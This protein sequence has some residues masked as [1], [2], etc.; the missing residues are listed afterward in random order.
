VLY[1]HR[2]SIAPWR[3]D[4][5]LKKDYI[6]QGPARLVG[7]GRSEADCK[8]I[9][10]HAAPGTFLPLS[11]GGFFFGTPKCRTKNSFFFLSK[12]KATG[13]GGAFHPRLMWEIASF[14]CESGLLSYADIAHT[15]FAGL[16]A[17]KVPRRIHTLYML[18]MR[19]GER[20]RPQE[21]RKV[22]DREKQPRNRCRC[23]CGC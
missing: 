1:I 9:P 4:P 19:T 7:C 8:V 17:E 18:W 22:V 2:R 20:D 16:S 3:E 13:E 5:W 21:E 6:P 12:I 15:T 11:A 23:S 14:C 10:T